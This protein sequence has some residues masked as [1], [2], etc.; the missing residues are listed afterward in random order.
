MLNI[1]NCYGNALKPQ[2]AT[3]PHLATRMAKIKK[4]EHTKC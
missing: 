3:T 1:I 2:C 4:I